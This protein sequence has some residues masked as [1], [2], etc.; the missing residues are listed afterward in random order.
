[1]LNL[2]DAGPTNVSGPGRS[3]SDIDEEVERLRAVYAE[4]TR[5]TGLQ[6][7]YSASSVANQLRARERQDALRR[8]IERRF[9]GSLQGL[10]I[11]DAGCGSTS[12]LSD[13]A[14]YGAEPERFWGIDLMPERVRLAQTRHPDATFR[15]GRLDQLPFGPA[16]FD[17]VHQSTVL[18][19]ILSTEARSA[20]TGEMDRVLKPGGSVL[21]YD[22]WINPTN[23]NARGVALREIRRLFPDYSLDLE[24]ITLAPPISRM[25]LRFGTRVHGLLSTLRPL[26]THYLGVLTKPS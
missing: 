6:A 19:S 1:M 5:D 26:R 23:R 7:R 24:Q 22:Y 8:V 9:G 3:S 13:L 25:A 21:W 10:A 17:I 16:T 18:S 15:V 12:I 11:L 20:A 4:R 2:P 14:Q